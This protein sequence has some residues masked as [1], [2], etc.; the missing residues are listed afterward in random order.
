MLNLSKRLYQLLSLALLILTMSACATND[1]QKKVGLAFPDLDNE[2]W[3][4][5]EA[6]LS[7]LLAEKGY[8]VVS[9]VANQDARL[10]S[11]Q[12]DNLVAEGV[13]AIIVVA[14]DGNAIV[15]AVE[16]AILADVRVLAYDRLIKSP[17]ISAYLSFD[18]RE[19][20][21]LQ[22][23]GLLEALDIDNRPAIQRMVR[24][25][26]LSSDPTDHNVSLYNL[27]QADAF[28][29]YIQERR[30]R[31]VA[32]EIIT[33][34]EQISAQ[35]LMETI[36]KEEENDV[37]GVLVSNEIIAQGV[38]QAL[39]AA[40]LEDVI[41]VAGQESSTTANG[42]AKGELVF[43]VFR[44]TRDLP[45]LA[46]SILDSILKEK[47][48]LELDRCLMSDLTGD[49]TQTGTIFCVL[50]PVQPLTQ[51]SLFDLVVKSGYESYDDVYREIPDGSR[52]A[53]P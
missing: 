49:E 41:F 36:L 50:L 48:L 13:K 2:R 4:R 20:G 1:P 19:A 53:R 27:G 14:V 29:P 31:L 8:E 15:P 40:G 25:V 23:S 33:S 18:N 11:D 45:P 9:L 52:P 7:I 38:V 16:A 32:D 26:R 47:S 44:D 3:R 51:D 22:A 34:R 46:V 10:Q 17:K 28:A 30:V 24:L 21:R 37:D 43:S 35:R 39:Q 5:E 12:I 6:M 42:I